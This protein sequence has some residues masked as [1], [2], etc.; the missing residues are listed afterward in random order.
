MCE[1]RTLAQVAQAHISQCT[2]CKTVFLWHN[3]LLLNFP[4]EDFVQFSHALQQRVFDDYCVPFPDGEE[5][6]IMHSPSPDISFSFTRAE[7]TDM[8]AAV[9]EAL[10]MQQ[11]YALI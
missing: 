9:S 8:R 5:R 2:Y 10:L 4:Q 7:W 11:V 1:N 6:V 3:N